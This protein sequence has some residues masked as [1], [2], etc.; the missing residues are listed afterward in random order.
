[1]IRLIT[2]FDNNFEF[3]FNTEL[4]NKLI[5]FGEADLSIF[6]FR[7]PE[8]IHYFIFDPNEKINNL[9]EILAKRLEFMINKANDNKAKVFKNLT[10]VGIMRN[11]LKLRNFY[12]PLHKAN[13]RLNREIYLDYNNGVIEISSK[14]LSKL[15][16][17]LNDYARYILRKNLRYL[18][19]NLNYEFFSYYDYIKYFQGLRNNLK[20]IVIEQ[21]NISNNLNTDKKTLIMDY[22]TNIP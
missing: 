17:T 7:R 22:L 10:L 9:K 3:A 21:Y 18:A 6:C 15:R 11:E 20:N 14:K 13:K 8:K 2:Y 19:G 5:S 16:L 12:N 1:M 4:S